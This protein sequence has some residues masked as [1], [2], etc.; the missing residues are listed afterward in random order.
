MWGLK[1]PLQ[2]GWISY[3]AQVGASAEVRRALAL[4]ELALLV[5]RCKSEG[6]TAN[7][8]CAGTPIVMVAPRR[9]NK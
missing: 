4:L 1:L 2:D 5:R 9:T 8:R 3:E 7:W 6:A